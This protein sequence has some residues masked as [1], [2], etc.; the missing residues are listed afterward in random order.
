M[1]DYSDDSTILLPSAKGNKIIERD[2]KDETTVLFREEVCYLINSD[3][4]RDGMHSSYDYTY[5]T[6]MY[7][8]SKDGDDYIF[9]IYDG[10]T[11]SFSHFLGHSLDMN[12]SD[13]IE[14]NKSKVTRFSSLA[15][16]LG[17]HN[18]LN[19]LNDLISIAKN[20]KIKPLIDNFKTLI[21]Q[22][23]K[24]SKNKL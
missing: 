16:E 5:L 18:F 9:H 3:F 22:E 19:K 7:I 17:S 2:F 23:R 20:S 24:I 13:M 8:I 6:I 4:Y 12:S 1:T 15:A 10:G 11:K 21:K 14:Y